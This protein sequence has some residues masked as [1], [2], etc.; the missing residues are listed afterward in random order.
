MKKYIILTLSFFLYQTNATEKPN[1]K[2]INDYT[3]Q[4]KEADSF[5]VLDNKTFYKEATER[6]TAGADRYV[7]QSESAPA[8]VSDR[9]LGFKNNPST[10]GRRIMKNPQ[11]R[12]SFDSTYSIDQYGR[13]MHVEKRQ[14]FCKKF[15][16][17]FGCSFT[18]GYGLNED[19]T[20]SYY[21]NTISES[22][23]C[24]YNYGTSGTGTNYVAAII[25][26][27]DFAVQIPEKKGTFIYVFMDEHIRR[28]VGLHPGTYYQRK[29]PYFEKNEK[30]ELVSKGSINQMRPVFLGVLR[31]FEKFFGDNILKDRVFPSRSA[32]D[33]Q[34][35]C[36]LLI[37]IEKKIKLSYAGS[38]FVVYMHSY[39]PTDP[40]IL[41]CLKENKIEYIEGLQI[42][43]RNEYTI[44]YH[45]HPNAKWNKIIAEEI[46]K[47]LESKENS[48]IETGLSSK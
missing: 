39:F 46:F 2:F 13:R 17:T 47:Y 5:A 12:L 28:S 7:W 11:G 9:T 48:I 25:K 41:S 14:R 10:Y 23:F 44:P 45:G 3:S 22:P 42:A 26:N 19:E 1:Y 36:D 35:V 43:D 6:H 20:I 40:E 31:Y 37:D 8:Q 34:Y 4:K 21:L 15:I 30:G 29:T 24:V 32:K 33:I 27:T 16:A 38:S 18:F